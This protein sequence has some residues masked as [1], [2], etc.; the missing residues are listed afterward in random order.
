MAQS[1]LWRQEIGNHEAALQARLAE[2]PEWVRLRAALAAAQREGDQRQQ[3][4]ATALRQQSLQRLGVTQQVATIKS[5]VAI[6]NVPPPAATD[7]E[8][9]LSLAELHR[10]FYEASQRL[11]S[12]DELCRG[13]VATNEVLRQAIAANDQM[14]KERLEANAEWRELQEA[15]QSSARNH[16][17]AR[18]AAPP[19]LLKPAARPSFPPTT[20]E[21]D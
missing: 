12:E 2:D 3:Q 16:R 8:S 20:P 11:R 18:Q 6:T 4:R 13:L 14:V 15:W 1:T 9:Q 5:A 10:A 7:A 21:L 17:K 19:L